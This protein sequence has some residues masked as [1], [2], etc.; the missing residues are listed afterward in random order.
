VRR[1]SLPR[2]LATRRASRYDRV[3]R[4]AALSLL[5]V[6]GTALADGEIRL[7]VRVGETVEREV[8]YARGWFCDDASLL[9]GDMVTRGDRNYFVVTGVKPG[10][11]NCRVGEAYSFHY[12]FEVHVLAKR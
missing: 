1:R 6:A 4:I 2:T 12:V 8:G 7:D 9:H 10:V 5:L 3:M 11:T